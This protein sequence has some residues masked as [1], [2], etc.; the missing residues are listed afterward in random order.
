MRLSA[1]A[2]AVLAAGCA[3][4]PRWYRGNTH[5]HTLWSDG[6]A[7]P[8]AVV[9]WYVSHGYD[10]LVLSDHNVVGDEYNLGQEME[11]EEAERKSWRRVGTGRG[12]VRPDHLRALR[13]RF[14]ADSVTLRDGQDGPEMRLK[15]LEDLRATFERP[16]R[17]ILIRGEEISDKF[18][19]KP[20]HHNSINQIHLIRPPGGTSVRDVMRRT[21]RAVYN[22]AFMTGRPV[23][24]HLNHPNFGWAVTP[25]DI[26]AVVE[27]RFFEVY[28]G[29]RGVRNY[30][31]ADHPGTEATWDYVLAARLGVLHGPPL[32][33][34]ATDDAHNYHREQANAGPG[35]GWVMVRAE[36]LTPAAITGALL[37][38]DFYASSGVSL[39][40]VR[41]DETSLTVEVLPEEGVTYTIRFIGTRVTGRQRFDSLKLG[42]VLQES[43]GSSASYTFRGD[44]LYVRATV[45]SDRPHPDGYAEGDLETAW[46]QP[47]IPD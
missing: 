21:M 30:G 12:Q 11:A 5:T 16:D 32:F 14:G 31:D 23:L 13:E 44:E 43:K 7:A 3:A 41:R 26:A 42:E 38:G 46:V 2:A 29:H 35:R 24:V 19:N 20:I 18:E 27:E 33:A 34:L 1:M 28:N 6:D 15:T 17:F 45:V 4:G 10:F 47:V 37:R 40:D 9:D 25:D 39:R 22:E 8:E 36:A